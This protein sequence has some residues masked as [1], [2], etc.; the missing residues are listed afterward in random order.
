MSAPRVTSYYTPKSQPNTFKNTV[1]IYGINTI[2]RTSG[3]IP[4]RIRQQ[5]RNTVLI[6][7]DEENGNYFKTPLHYLMFSF[8]N[9]FP[10]IKP[11]IWSPILT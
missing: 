3:C 11:S 2:L 9:D 1:L 8:K 5:R 4:T 7:F 6:K 10:L